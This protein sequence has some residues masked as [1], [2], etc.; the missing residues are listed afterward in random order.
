MKGKKKHLI[1][2]HNEKPTITKA[3]HERVGNP[4]S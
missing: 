3:K 4:K 2:K 1:K